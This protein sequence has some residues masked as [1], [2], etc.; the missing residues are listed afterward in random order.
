MSFCELNDPEIDTR[1][2]NDIRRPLPGHYSKPS[3]QTRD[4]DFNLSDINTSFKK[5]GSIKS[6]DQPKRNSL[7]HNPKTLSRFKKSSSDA[8]RVNPSILKSP[9]GGKKRGQGRS[10]FAQSQNQGESFATNNKKRVQFGAIKYVRNYNP[11]SES[12]NNTMFF[13]QE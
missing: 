5:T 7:V 12:N 13:D 8:A 11:R 3:S 4:S 1:V 10:K 2:D 6:Q 9:L